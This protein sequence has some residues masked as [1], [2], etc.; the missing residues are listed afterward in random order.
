MAIL[1]AVAACAPRLPDPVPVPEPGELAKRLQVAGTPDQPQLIAFQWRYR[2]REGR[3]SGE[4]AVRTNPP[5]SVRLD[6]LGPGWSGVQSAIL[7]GDDVYYIGEQRIELP[8]PAFMWT[9]LGVFRP[10]V[11]IEPAAARRGDHSQLT[12][13]LS[14]RESLVYI[15]DPAG[16]LIEAELRVDGDAVQEIR[17]EPSSAGADAGAWRWPQEARFRDLGEFHEVRIKVTEIREH[18]PFER[19]IFEVAV[20]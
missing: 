15:F 18:E 20:P 1:A 4:G 5:D 12:Y 17:V 16:R 10:P 9:L 11:G 7:L 8:P 6:L 3:F 19:R 2:G 13:A 14:S